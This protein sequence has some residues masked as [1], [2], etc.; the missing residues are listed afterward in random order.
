M[1]V[2]QIVFIIVIIGLIFGMPWVFMSLWNYLMPVMFPTATIGIL[3]YWQAWGVII[4]GRVI[5]HNTSS[6]NK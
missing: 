4:M 5:T 2:S 3:S 6:G 1:T